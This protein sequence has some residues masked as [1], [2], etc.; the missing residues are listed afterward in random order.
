[1]IGQS[2]ASFGNSGREVLTSFNHCFTPKTLS[3]FENSEW[4]IGHLSLCNV[5]W[6]VLRGSVDPLFKFVEYLGLSVLIEDNVSQTCWWWCRPQTKQNNNAHL[7]IFLD[8]LLFNWL[9]W[10]WCFLWEIMREKRLCPFFA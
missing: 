6:K 10:R 7:P 1:M 3:V 9:C 5:H 4:N 8:I 2:W